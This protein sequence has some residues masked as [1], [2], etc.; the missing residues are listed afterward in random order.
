VKVFLDTNVLAY[1]FDDSQP[2][3][4]ARARQAF[5]QAAE[6]AVISTQVLIELHRVLTRKLGRSREDARAALETL[7]LKTVPADRELVIAAAI[8]AERH[9]L[10]IFDAMI[11]EAAAHAGCTEV[12]T[13]DL[14]TGSDLRGVHVVNPFSSLR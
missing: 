12:W 4:Q 1:Q 9:Q 3:K 7:D 5:E 2:A 8:T 6:D 13:E 11:I 10:S 14:A